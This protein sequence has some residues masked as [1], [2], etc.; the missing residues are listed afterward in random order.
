MENLVPAII[1]AINNLTDEFTTHELI[2][3]LA[4]SEQH[5]YIQALH[6]HLESE[7]P[8]QSLHSKIGKFL[9]QSN[10]LVNSAGSKRDADI[11][12]QSSDNAIWKKSA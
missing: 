5:A 9:A 11:F 7:K 6:D 2:M 3:Q 12:G 8:F 1:N 10:H 4:K